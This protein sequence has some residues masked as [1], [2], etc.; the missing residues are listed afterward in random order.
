LIQ[1]IR[2]RAKTVVVLTVATVN[3]FAFVACLVVHVASLAGLTP[4]SAVLGISAVGLIAGTFVTHMAV[5]DVPGV[6]I[7][8]RRH[9]APRPR[10]LSGAW[11]VLML[12]FAVNAFVFSGPP[13]H[14]ETAAEVHAFDRANWRILSAFAL[15]WLLELVYL[16]SL[17]CWQLHRRKLPR[18]RLWPPLGYHARHHDQHRRQDS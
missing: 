7:G 15:A 10:W 2:S 18:A 13:R 17:A 3:L 12:Y 4:S 8:S 14:A 16:S 1:L 6:E 11:F 9:P 5:G